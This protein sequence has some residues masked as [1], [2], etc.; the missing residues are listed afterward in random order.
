MVEHAAWMLAGAAA[1]ALLGMAWLALAMDPHWAQV[2]GQAGP[3][4]RQQQGLRLLGSIALAACLGL[5]L[6][7]D[8]ATM[9]VLVWAMLM[10]GAAVVIAMTLAWR[11]QGLRLLWSK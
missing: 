9:A 6:V 11:P 2:H 4:P 5:C 7:S 3:A 1:L 10:A 8:H